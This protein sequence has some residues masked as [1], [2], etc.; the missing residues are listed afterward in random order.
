MKNKFSLYILSLLFLLSSLC[1]AQLPISRQ[2]TLLE[3]SSSSEL[4]LEATGFYHTD[5]KFRKK[6]DVKKH[7]IS[8]A[9]IDAKKA[10]IYYLL[11]GGADPILSTDKELNHFKF[12][13]N[14]F[15]KTDNITTFITYEDARPQKT[16]LL[17]KG[18]GIKVILDV[19]VDKARLIKVLEDEG[20]I[21]KKVTL[22]DIVGNPFI[23]V[24]PQLEKGQ[25]ISE[26]FSESKD[27]TH[28]AG[29]IQSY[30]TAQ[31]YDVVVPDQ[32]NFINT[33]NEQQLSLVGKADDTSYQLALS[34]GSDV[35][36]DYSVTFSKSSYET[37]K[38]AVSVRAFETTTS[39]LLGAETGYSDSR[40]GDS[41]VS[42]EEAI[43]DAMTNV[44]SRVHNYWESD[45]EKGV[46]Y[47][48]ITTF[49]KDLTGDTKEA[50]TD[51]YFDTLEDVS[52][53]VKE[54]T[55]GSTTIDSTIWVSP[56]DYKNSRKLYRGLRESFN[57][58]SSQFKL[59]KS[60]QN[61]K[62]LLLTVTH[63]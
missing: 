6:A 44:M 46:Q 10:A 20:V 25:T 12:L 9:I 27:N 45:L 8:N 48:V 23:M 14:D 19:K 17:N 38:A 61:R 4:F 24:L 34:V 42:I 28:A 63:K 5:K 37:K 39:R 29:V 55:S 11:Y 26:A 32:Q 1:F 3:T 22:L 16:V 51:A 62:L 50:I 15:F 49:P 33:L 35:Y 60:H 31:Q 56:T 18:T 36:I 30:L 47:K 57:N 53:T 40:E 7:G 21:V 59:S 41:F 52:E 43:L 2:A 13:E 58:E 54:N